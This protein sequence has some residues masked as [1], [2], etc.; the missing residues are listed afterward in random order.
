MYITCMRKKLETYKTGAKW[1]KK[2]KSRSESREIRMTENMGFPGG[3]A[4]KNL[5]ATQEMRVQSLDEEAPLKG[6]AI[7]SSILAW[8]IP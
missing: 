1:G 6:M 5:P 8:K 2:K 3:S 4:V 7:Y